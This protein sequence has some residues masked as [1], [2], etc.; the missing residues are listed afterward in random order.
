MKKRQQGGMGMRRRGNWTPAVRVTTVGAPN[1][2]RE[3][4][5]GLGDIMTIAHG[6]RT[7]RV[8]FRDITPP[9]AMAAG[10]LT[11]EEERLTAGPPREEVGVA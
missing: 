4:M 2:D 9:N 5:L 1:G 10:P 11:D 6:Q 7:Y 3:V 8:T